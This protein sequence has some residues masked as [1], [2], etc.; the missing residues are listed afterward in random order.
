MT[1]P[2]RSTSALPGLSCENAEAGTPVAGVAGTAVFAA[3][4][5]PL[6]GAVVASSLVLPQPAAT[7]A[8]ASSDNRHKTCRRVEPIVI[9]LFRGA[10]TGDS[11]Q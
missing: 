10:A 11:T 9:L 1:C 3:V 5:A 8:A 6:P 4:D 2:L 7:D